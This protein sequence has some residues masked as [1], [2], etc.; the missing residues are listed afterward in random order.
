MMVLVCGAVSC[1]AKLVVTNEHR[2]C[3][4]MADSGRPHDLSATVL[5]TRAALCTNTI[6]GFCSLLKRGIIG[7]YHNV[8]KKL[9]LYFT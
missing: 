1:R 8:S 3:D 5:R 4:T 9:P 2:G 6:E 7:T